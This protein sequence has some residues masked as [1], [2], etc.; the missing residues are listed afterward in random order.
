[1]VLTSVGLS[2]QE[3]RASSSKMRC[4]KW[5]TESVG[6][7]G[8]CEGPEEMEQADFSRVSYKHKQKVLSSATVNKG[9]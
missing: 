5:V 3:V 4:R 1:M 2:S 9:H 8:V 7:S 6:V